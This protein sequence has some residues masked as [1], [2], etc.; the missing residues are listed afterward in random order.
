MT[1]PTL[2][3]RAAGAGVRVDLERLVWSKLLIQAGSGFGKSWAVRQL[4]EETF[5]RIPQIVID[6]EGE[7]HTLREKFDYVLAAARGGDVEA[8]PRTA[9]VLAR[10]LVEHSA[11]AVLDLSEL[12]P[13]D[14]KR[15]IRIFLETMLALPRE[16]W[17]PTLVIVDEIQIP[18]PEKG[19]GESEALDTVSDFAAR[20]RKRGFCLIGATQRLSRFNKDVAAQLHNKLIGFASLDTDIDRSAKEL[21]FDKDHR[22]TISRLDPGQFYAFGPAIA[23]EVTLVKTGP[24][25]TTHP[26]AGTTVAVSSFPASSK[27]KALITSALADLP[28]EAEQEARTIEDLK[29]DNAKLR[30]DLTRAQKAQP[31]ASAIAKADPSEIQRLAM[32]A[33]QTLVE[34]RAKDE[35]G[36]IR[37]GKSAITLLEKSVATFAADVADRVVPGLRKLIDSLE[38]PTSAAAP[39]AP[40]NGNGHHKTAVSAAP[41]QTVTR[42][43]TQGSI[44][45]RSAPRRDPSVDGIGKGE[46]KVLAAI[47]SYTDGVDRNQLSVLTGYKRSSR[48]T[49]IQ[50][51]QAAGLI[52]VSGSRI[53]A[54]DAGIDALGSDFEPLPT[55]VALQEYWLNRLSGGEHEILSAL[56]ESWPHAVLRSH[57]DE[58]TGYK[59][60]SRDTYLQRLQARRLVESVG[61]AEVRA[62]SMLFEEAGR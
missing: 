13:S 26:K 49:Y 28:K 29:R 12:K 31:A 9:A 51:L 46:A 10:R 39:P 59:R 55:G 16:L 3:Y 44:S 25:Q 48:D 6:P 15:F 17:H 43:V 2:T 61:R 22:A 4:C 24:V 19:H 14:Q 56:I 52:E 8:T 41:R 20:S 33:F 42:P 50:R 62:S 21:G 40:T 7:F 35:A 32:K 30:G 36:T 47:A 5:G 45:R 1:T 58:V 11:S 18:A 54:T 38:S 53:T 57:L 60:S 34:G 23:K 37:A 27:V